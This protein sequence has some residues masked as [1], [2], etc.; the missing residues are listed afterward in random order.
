M[1]C[2]SITQVSSG[3]WLPTHFAVLRV[4]RSLAVNTKS[5]CSFA[6]SLL[7]GLPHVPSC[8]LRAWFHLFQQKLTRTTEQ[9][10]HTYRYMCC[11]QLLCY[12]PQADS[13][14]QSKFAKAASVM[15][16]NSRYLKPR[17]SLQGRKRLQMIKCPDS[18]QGQRL[19]GSLKRCLKKSCVTVFVH[20]N[21]ITRVDVL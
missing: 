8:S 14:T 12:L 7:F 11:N 4:E 21:E 10:R 19:R 6:G 16:G 9:N 20:Q 13:C 3:S 15:P 1:H 18:V 17:L 2:V 5:A